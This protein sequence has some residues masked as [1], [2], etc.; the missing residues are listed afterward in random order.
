M[1]RFLNIF[2]ISLSLFCN[3]QKTTEKIKIEK[4]PK[5]SE[6]LSEISEFPEISPEFP[7]G[8][9]ALHKFISANTK[10]PNECDKAGY[11]LVFVNFIIEK[12]GSVTQ[13]RILR[14]PADCPQYGDE[15]LRVV[16]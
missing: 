4:E 14:A 16:R 2:F 13:A 11:I 15:V 1:R 3:A 10:F 6:E 9:T 8:F 5:Q 12:D 7:G